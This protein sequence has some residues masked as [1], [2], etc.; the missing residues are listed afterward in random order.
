MTVDTYTPPGTADSQRL[1]D[2][3][4]I[5]TAQPDPPDVDL[6]PQDHQHHHG[7][8]HSHVR[9]P[10]DVLRL[11][12]G[13]VII[14]VGIGV[15]N[16]FDSALLGLSVDGE[17]ALGGLPNWV[18]S[19]TAALVSAVVLGVVAGSSIWALITTRYR[20]LTLLVSAVAGAVALSIG[21][22]HLLFDVVDADVRAALDTSSPLLRYSHNDGM[23]HPGDPL[24][25]GAIA[26]LAVS[27]S[28]LRSITI[29]RIAMLLGLYVVATTLTIHIPALGL[30]SDVGVGLTVGSLLLLF[31]GRHDLAPNKQEIHDALAQIGIEVEDLEHL[32]VDARASAPWMGDT[33]AGQPVFVKALGRDER[34]ADLMFR[35]Y[36]WLKLRRTGDHRPFVSLR[37]SVEHEALVSLQAAALG[38]R[39][40]ESWVL[41]APGSTAWRLPMKASPAHR[42]THSTT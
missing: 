12:I 26:M 24:L 2:L 33:P 40:R 17:T 1:I 39:S 25:A 22:G 32:D 7:E 34:S 37:R 42:P 13:L 41:L 9:S 31:A 8:R 29:R 18:D 38:V 35:F 20:R 30:L 5:D 15:A 23:I 27:T 21:V 10:V 16:L 6:F 19:I 36:R 3:P 28:F 11:I 4:S 14:V